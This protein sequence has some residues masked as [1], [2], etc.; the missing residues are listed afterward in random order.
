MDLKLN[1]DQFQMLQNTNNGCRKTSHVCNYRYYSNSI[2]SIWFVVLLFYA[3]DPQ[4]I[5]PIEFECIYDSYAS[6]E[7]NAVSR[8]AAYRTRV[9]Q[10]NEI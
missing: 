1:Q 10:L 2:G 8:H 3:T 7:L 4:Q 9:R 5:D 6:S